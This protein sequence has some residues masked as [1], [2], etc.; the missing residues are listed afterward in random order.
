MQK[1]HK[2]INLNVQYLTFNELDNGNFAV[3]LAGFFYRDE[4]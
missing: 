2:L 1:S 4:L 3:F